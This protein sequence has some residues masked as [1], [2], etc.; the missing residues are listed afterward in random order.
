MCLPM[1]TVGAPGDPGSDDPLSRGRQG[2]DGAPGDPGVIGPPG[3]T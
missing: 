3:K 2:P 1:T